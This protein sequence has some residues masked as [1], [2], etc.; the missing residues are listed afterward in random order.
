MGDNITKSKG[1][2]HHFTDREK[3]EALE[4]YREL[5][6]SEVQR[7]YEFYDKY[8]EQVKHKNFKSDKYDFELH[9]QFSFDVE[10]CKRR[11]LHAAESVRKNYNAHIEV[12]NFD[13]LLENYQNNK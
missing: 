11:M 8:L 3:E 12:P 5:V 10:Q 6:V 2:E 13:V 9:N 7:M 4:A 1:S